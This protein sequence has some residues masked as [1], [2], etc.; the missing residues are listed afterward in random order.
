[1]NTALNT[2]Y[3]QLEKMSGHECSSIGKLCSCSWHSAFMVNL[4]REQDFFVM[5][6]FCFAPDGVNSYSGFQ[7]MISMESVECERRNNH[8]AIK[9]STQL[10]I[11]DSSMIIS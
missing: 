9:A 11:R 10:H 3:S 4:Q 7:S 1:M 6:L 8:L 5:N 2:V